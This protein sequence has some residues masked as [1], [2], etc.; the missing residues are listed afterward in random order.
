[1]ANTVLDR[2]SQLIEPRAAYSDDYEE[3]HEDADED[4]S[5]HGKRFVVDVHVKENS[6]PKAK[7]ERPADKRRRS[8]HVL[9]REAKVRPSSAL[10][11]RA[12]VREPKHHFTQKKKWGETPSTRTSL[13]KSCKD[14]LE[15]KRKVS[16]KVKR[17]KRTKRKRKKKTKE[18]TKTK[19]WF[20]KAEKGKDIETKEKVNTGREGENVAGENEGRAKQRRARHLVVQQ[21]P[22][23]IMSATTKAKAQA[24][25]RVSE[26]T[27][28]MTSEMDTGRH[29]HDGNGGGALPA[30]RARTLSAIDAEIKRLER[31]VETE[32]T[33]AYRRWKSSLTSQQQQS[34]SNILCRRRKRLKEERLKKMERGWS[35]RDPVQVSADGLPTR[36]IPSYN[37]LAVSLFQK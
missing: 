37:A 28:T 14:R 18:K 22:T 5:L 3:D 32:L 19:K 1:M 29:F 9:A 26:A 13:D 4:S 36:S 35:T 11:R 17:T 24:R 10:P 25:T 20:S 6:G 33:S 2:C 12:Y 8:R 15:Q 23:R 7:I 27:G 31:A 16:K 34:V 30:P 21:G